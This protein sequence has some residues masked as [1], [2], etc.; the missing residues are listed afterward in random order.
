MNLYL[1]T[2]AL[3]K[4]Y[5][6][7]RGSFMVREALSRSTFVASSAVARAE[8]HAALARRYR[9]R[10]ISLSSL[11]Q[12]V[13]ELDEDL[14]RFVIMDVT[15][16]LAKRAGDLAE[17]HKL[18]GFDAVHLA[19]ALEIAASLNE[20]VVFACFDEVLTTAALAEQLLPFERP[21]DEAT[22]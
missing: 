7:E 8:A 11:R 9:E 16:A 4:L 15:S 14:N 19:S 1:D 17:E 2:S 10:T 6:D 20:A 5:L 21:G 13:A 18:M 3:V 22:Q 12:H